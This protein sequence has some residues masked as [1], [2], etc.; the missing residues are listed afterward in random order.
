MTNIIFD[1]HSTYLHSEAPVS[2][3]Q[4]VQQW[5]PNKADHTYKGNYN[6]IF[7]ALKLIIFDSSYSCQLPWAHI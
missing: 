3:D 1:L 4:H 5:T 2:Q 7:E 6:D